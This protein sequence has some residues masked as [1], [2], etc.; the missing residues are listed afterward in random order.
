[1]RCK[2]AQPLLS[3]ELDGRL[4]ARQAPA[5]AEHLAGCEACRASRQQMAAAWDLLGASPAASAPDDWRLIAARLEAAPT[6]VWAWFG[7]LWQETPSRWAT[8]AV[9]AVFLVAG[10]VAGSWLAKG[11]KP[12]LPVE[13]VAMAEAF[14]DVPGSVWLASE[15]P[16]RP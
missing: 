6:G 15:G 7:A 12:A 10:G 16:V 2:K 13:A 11:L 5:L 9:V 1:M 14:G 8:A 3:L 4:T